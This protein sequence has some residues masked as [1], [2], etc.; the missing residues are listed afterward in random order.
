MICHILENH[1]HKAVYQYEYDDDVPK[2]KTIKDIQV[3]KE[4]IIND[5]SNT[6]VTERFATG[7]IFAHVG[8]LTSMGTIVHS[9]S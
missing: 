8:S 5:K 7:F 9:Q 3:N 6:Y 2:K 4:I 1:T